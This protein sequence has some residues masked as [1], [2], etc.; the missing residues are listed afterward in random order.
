[1]YS[2]AGISFELHNGL[3]EFNEVMEYPEAIMK[4]Y[5]VL[6]S[7]FVLIESVCGLIKGMI[8]PACIFHMNT[9]APSCNFGHVLQL[10]VRS[11]SSFNFTTK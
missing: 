8:H 5:S 4:T 3:L 9:R 2:V 6:C 10:T 11:E 7:P 1:M